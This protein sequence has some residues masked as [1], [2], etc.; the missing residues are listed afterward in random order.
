MQIKDEY[1]GKTVIVYNSVLGNQSVI[2]DQMLP[3]HYEWYSRNGLAHIFEVE[4]TIKLTFE[5]PDKEIE[6]VSVPIVKK[7]RTKKK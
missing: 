7:T 6:D 5:K 4:A 1:K 2:I 3:K